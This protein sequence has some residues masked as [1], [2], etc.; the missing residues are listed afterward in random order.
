[1]SL[2]Q[3]ATLEQPEAL[4]GE[5]A[6]VELADG[7]VLFRRLMPAA[8]PALFDLA[9]TDGPTLRGVAVLRARRVLGVLHPEAFAPRDTGRA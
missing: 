2:S 6:I 9:A 5:A 7:R 1:M 3:A 4:F 8:D